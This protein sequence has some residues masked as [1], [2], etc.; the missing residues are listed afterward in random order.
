MIIH[1]SFVYKSRR[2]GNNV[3]VHQLAAIKNDGYSHSTGW[4]GTLCRDRKSL[5]DLTVKWKK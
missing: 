3:S 4:V 5:Q 1:C 2:V